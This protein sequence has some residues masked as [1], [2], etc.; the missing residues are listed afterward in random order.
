MV[1]QQINNPGAVAGQ[2]VGNTAAYHMFRG[3]KATTFAVN[4]GDILVK[5]AATAPDTYKINAAGAG[6][7]GPFYIATQRAEIGDDKVSL[8]DNGLWYVVAGDAIEV[9]DPVALSATVAGQCVKGAPITTSAIQQATV[10]TCYGFQDNYGTGKHLATT[11][12]DLMVLNL[13]H[14]VSG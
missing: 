9:G 8:A 4:K 11:A 14:S 12:G 6:I 5:D 1:Q 3:Q 7:L 13:G 2:P 10:G